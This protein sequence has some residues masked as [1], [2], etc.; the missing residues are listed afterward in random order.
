[1][2]PNYLHLDL[3]LLEGLH[4]LSDPDE[5]SMVTE[6]LEIFETT[7]PD[8]LEKLRLH[9]SNNELQ[10]VYAI[11]HR[12]KG[13]ASNIGASA[14]A[15]IC[16]EMEQQAKAGTGPIDVQLCESA[17]SLF[18]TSCIEIRTWLKEKTI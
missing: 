13:S 5:P 10:A 3:Q 9:I 18:K 7:T 14:L 4:E 6:L 11:A 2:N 16:S 17:D 12:L 1:M 15:L 8:L